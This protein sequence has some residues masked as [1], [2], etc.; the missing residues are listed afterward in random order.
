MFDTGTCSYNMFGMEKL[1]M[2][3]YMV[4]VVGPSLVRDSEILVARAPPEIL[5]FAQPACTCAC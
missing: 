5:M 2:V 1:E 4:Q 3:C